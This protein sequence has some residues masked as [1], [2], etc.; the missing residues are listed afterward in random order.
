MW[1]GQQAKYTLQVKCTQITRDAANALHCS[2]SMPHTPVKSL[3]ACIDVSLQEQSELPFWYFH[4]IL[5][6]V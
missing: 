1:H 4:A 5:S 2:S 6:F 3:H